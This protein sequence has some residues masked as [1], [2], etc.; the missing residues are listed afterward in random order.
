MGQSK[1]SSV[2]HPLPAQTKPRAPRAVC[3]L[4]FNIKPQLCVLLEPSEAG[5]VQRSGH[6]ECSASSPCSQHTS[7]ARPDHISCNIIPCGRGSTVYWCV[8]IFVPPNSCTDSAEMTSMAARSGTASTPRRGKEQLPQVP[9]P[10][11]CQRGTCCALPPETRSEPCS[12]DPARRS[13]A[14]TPQ[15]QHTQVSLAC[16]PRLLENRPAQGKRDAQDVAAPGSRSVGQELKMS[17]KKISAYSNPSLLPREHRNARD[18]YKGFRNQ[19]FQPFFPSGH[20]HKSNVS[21]G[22]TL[23]LLFPPSCQAL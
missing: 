20:P 6:R 17:S 11:S 2:H 7:P 10:N 19:M 5:K 12:T 23:W 15:R 9:R 4:N 14:N 3:K 16:L 8:V 18:A 22:C 21:W 13:A 1:A